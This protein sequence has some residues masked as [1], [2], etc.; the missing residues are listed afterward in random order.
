[1]NNINYF[2]DLFEPI[3]DN[4]KIVLLK[5]LIQNDK[6]LLNEIGFNKKDIN[7]LNLE[8]RKILLEQNEEYLDYI[9][10]KEESIIERILNKEMEKF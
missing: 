7:Q 2:K 1:M 10:N 3:T 4:G 8:F 9:K 6:N 5:F